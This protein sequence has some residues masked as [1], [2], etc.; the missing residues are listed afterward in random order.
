[1]EE[2]GWWG[3]LFTGATEETSSSEAKTVLSNLEM[4]EIRGW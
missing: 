3:W 1:M 4:A 2:E